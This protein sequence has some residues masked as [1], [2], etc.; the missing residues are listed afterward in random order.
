MFHCLRCIF[1]LFTA[2]F[3]DKGNC[4]WEWSNTRI[5]VTWNQQHLLCFLKNFSIFK[6]TLVFICCLSLCDIITPAYL[7]ILNDLHLTAHNICITA[8]TELDLDNVPPVWVP[9]LY[10]VSQKKTDTLLMSITSQDVSRF[11]KFFH[12]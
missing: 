8:L 4:W 6:R 12:C 10:T 7:L 3:A 1:A 5:Y 11:S 2:V 9:A